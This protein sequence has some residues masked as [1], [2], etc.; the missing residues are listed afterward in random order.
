MS[1]SLLNLYSEEIIR[2]IAHMK[3]VNIGGVI[4]NKL[5]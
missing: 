2:K 1:P 4:V 5:R 3:G